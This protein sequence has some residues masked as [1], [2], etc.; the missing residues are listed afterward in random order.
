MAAIKNDPPEAT[1]T[2]AQ[3]ELI[4][5]TARRG[6]ALRRGKETQASH[7]DTHIYQM[8]A[9]L[10][11][12]IQALKEEERQHSLSSDDRMLQSLLTELRQDIETLKGEQEVWTRGRRE[13]HFVS[14]LAELR[15]DIE[16]LN[17]LSDVRGVSPSAGDRGG[18]RPADTGNVLKLGIP[19]GILGGVAAA[20]GLLLATG[21]VRIETGNA[22]QSAGGATNRSVTA[23]P[24]PVPAPVQG[25]RMATPD[26]LIQTANLLIG[27]GEIDFAR[28]VLVNAATQGN[29]TA[30]LMLAQTYDP[31]QLARMFNPRGVAPDPERAQTFYELAAS[32]GNSE[33]IA[34][35]DE[36]R[37]AGSSK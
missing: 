11:R 33:A 7:G 8:L 28:Q 12:D 19:L 34:R 29:G 13:R 25:P 36:L 22:V 14:R 30:A 21:T 35:L 17:L 15:Q 1:S 5:A 37:A 27:R 9:E 18:K 3:I 4:E 32:A 24:V 6:E 23:R 2:R 26:Q 31:S 10:R 20:F 16:A